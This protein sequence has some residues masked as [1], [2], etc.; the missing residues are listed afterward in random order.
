[1]K[2]ELIVPRT[3]TPVERGR[4]ALT[5]A[6]A[7]Q[8]ISA[9]RDVRAYVLLGDPG[10]GKTTE[11][12]QA[13]RAEG[14]V[15]VP[16]RRF[17]RGPAR[18]PEWRGKTLFI[19]GLDEMR[20]GAGDPR[21]A[22]DAI[23]GRLEKLDRPRVRI[24]CRAA[25]WLAGNDANELRSLP[26]YDDLLILRLDA[27]VE[28]DAERLLTY[29]GV[30]DAHEFLA[31]AQDCGLRG[32]LDN[33]LTLELLAKAF[34]MDG[35]WPDGKRQTFQMAC[36]ALA[37]EYNEQ[38][39]AARQVP[40]SL[41][42]EISAAGCWATLLLVGGKEHV[43]TVGAGQPDAGA[44]LSLRLEEMPAKAMPSGGMNALK[45]A[46]DTRLFSM[47]G[48]S[49]SSA[50]ALAPYHRSVAEHLA[51]RYL[52]E[53]I[54]EGGVP[55]GR[56]LALLAGADGVVV[57]SLRGLA[58][59]LA[60]FNSDARRRL[61]D[62]IPFDILASGDPSVFSP[63]C[64]DRLLHALGQLSSHRGFMLRRTS[65]AVRAALTSPETMGF[66]RRCIENDP[67]G[68]PQAVQSVVEL[69]FEGL[70]SDPSPCDLLSVGEAVAVARDDRWMFAARKQALDA[71]IR[72][73]EHDDE[74]Y[75]LLAGMLEDIS[76]GRVADVNQELRGKLVEGLYPH[77]LPPSQIPPLLPRAAGGTLTW[78]LSRALIKTEDARV[79][80]ILDALCVIDRDQADADYPDL[81]RRVSEEARLDLLDR[82]LRLH[83]ESVA[84]GRLYDWLSVHP[85]PK[86]LLAATGTKGDKSDLGPGPWLSQHPGIRRSLLRERVRRERHMLDE[87]RSHFRMFPLLF[88]GLSPGEAVALCFEEAVAA[89]ALDDARSYLDWAVMHRRSQ[90]QPLPG[91][92]FA[93]ALTPD[94]LEWATAQLRSK[95]EL[96]EYLERTAQREAKKRQAH[97]SR[98]DPYR[99]RMRQAVLQRRDL[100][101]K[102]TA[103][104]ELLE[105]AALVYLGI[106][107]MEPSLR[108]VERLQKWLADDVL[109]DD[110]ASDAVEAALRALRQV[111]EESTI[112]SLAQLLEF[113][114]EGKTYGL[115]D[116]V[117]AGLHYIG[118][119]EGALPATFSDDWLR[120]ALGLHYLTVVMDKDLPHWV[121][122]LLDA[123][124]RLVAET[125]AEVLT[126]HIRGR[127]DY[128]DHLL[129][130]D[131][132]RHASVLNEVVPKLLN[133]FPVRGTK[134]HLPKLRTIL[135]FALH[136]LPRDQLREVVERKLSFGSM[137]T[138]QKAVWLGV[139]LRAWPRCF[140][141]R[142]V[143]FLA[144]KRDATVRHLADA[145]ASGTGR[146]QFSPTSASV[147]DVFLLVRKFGSRYA[148]EW[149]SRR[150][151]AEVEAGRAF[152]VS[153]EEKI[154]E[155]TSALIERCIRYLSRE[156]KPDARQALQR[157]VDDP[158]LASWRDKLDQAHEGQVELRRETTHRPPS[159]A[160]IADV[161]SDG[162]PAN[163]VD[164]AELVADRLRHLASEIRDGNTDGWRPFWNDDP[165]DA[166]L[167]ALQPRLEPLNIDLQPERHYDAD[168]RDICAVAAGG[169]PAVPIEIKKSDSCDVWSAGRQLAKRYARDGAS[170]GHCVY[171]VLWFG[172]CMVPPSGP[173]PKSPGELK[174]QL[175]GQLAPDH[176]RFVRVSVIDV[177]HTGVAVSP[178]ER[179]RK[180][181]G[182]L[183]RGLGPFVER[184]VLKRV[185]KETVQMD[186][187]RR[188]AGDRKTAKRPLAEWDAAA[189][190]R[191]MLKMWNDVFR[192]SLERTEQSL[193]QELSDWRNKWAHQERFSSDDASRVLDSAARLLTAVSARDAAAEVEK[194]RAE[195]L[196]QQYDPQPR[197]QQKQAGGNG[198]GVGPIEET[199]SSAS[200]APRPSRRKP[201]ISRKKTY[202][203][204]CRV[205]YGRVVSYG[206]VAQVLGNPLAAQGVRSAL[207]ALFPTDVPWWRVVKKDGAVSAPRP[208]TGGRSQR[209][210]LEGEGVKFDAS[211]KV[212]ADF[213]W[214]PEETDD[215][216]AS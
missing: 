171:V 74:G 151:R 46:L 88:L 91:T 51:A 30:Q 184:E 107:P 3:V 28:A 19:D 78:R 131:Q 194:S 165:H 64:K 34:S 143:S 73:A 60:T 95:S 5:S 59:W 128:E 192:F 118:R 142:A 31:A 189:L 116:P 109:S 204:V 63:Q 100:L 55:A 147:E 37:G 137:D 208:D 197:K 214:D 43:E 202:A 117:L 103:P 44:D 153:E 49:G 145:W 9:F 130:L 157:L 169:T 76:A 25:A 170:G 122:A 50:S 4:E 213:W 155:K 67:T 41:D 38:H 126:A 176:R 72:V 20:A 47:A 123:K 166:L 158:A 85:E 8:P 105:E 133:A 177:A 172:D 132:D 40:V 144:G 7:S 154:H 179:V 206:K 54:D 186:A 168:K 207:R 129:S 152:T 77:H 21:M 181:L 1:M 120:S 108:P 94:W 23:L 69:L 174:D 121:R 141:G 104:P 17:I 159:L 12:K 79:P 185:Q 136:G 124:P 87:N 96:V 201:T 212:L 6:A 138:A 203:L 11:F 188:L 99:E 160:A 97:A 58:A 36:R 140:T 148:P 167:V 62:E 182:S 53:R 83:G 198:H 162:P 66:L 24:S 180:A 163:A 65:P 193:V 119:R 106:R 135:K 32:L 175:C 56:V 68:Q 200:R 183:R 113:K 13:E 191:V 187:V 82:G 110:D 80:D 48:G 115:A 209:D 75:D 111:V 150:S 39:R 26:G 211:G 114:Q 199:S 161:L 92:T 216:E 18:K 52:D 164:L 90:V 139:G 2:T 42:E 81:F 61:V 146:A 35:S 86:R 15:C 195:L 70:A 57:P 149:M 89:T 178:Y 173:C 45:R 84:V 101:L 205:P 14:D 22:L 71:A 98:E 127:R 27:L 210:R 29:H 10:S 93:E 16:A 196:R 33:P 102:G 215:G 112:P 190:L 125:L 134:W 156:P